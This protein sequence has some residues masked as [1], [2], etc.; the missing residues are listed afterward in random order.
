[1]DE[2]FQVVGKEPTDIA[3]AKRVHLCQLAGI[4]DEAPVAEDFVKVLE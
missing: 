4:D 3:N 2:L 1:M